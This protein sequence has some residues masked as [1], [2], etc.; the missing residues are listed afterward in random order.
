MGQN[1]SKDV[2]INGTVSPGYES[3]KEMFTDNFRK[4]RE[5]SA[6][7]CVYVGEEKV[8]DIW[9]STTI[10]SY[11]ADTLTNVFSSTKSLTAI[12][13]AVMQDR[14]LIKYGAKIA[15][16][17]PEFGQNGK[18]EVTV[19]DLMRH[20]A[21][22]ATWD[23]SLDVQDALT[24]NIK[25]NNVGKVIENQ[26]LNFP[27]TG[28]RQYHGITRGWIA[29]E[30]FRRVHPK[31]ETI[32]EFLQ[33]ELQEPLNADV[34]V[35]I[36]DA[37]VNNY[38]PVVDMKFS[39]VI[40]QSMIP[41]MF[42]R[43]VDVNIFELASFLNMIRKAIKKSD[44]MKPAF[45]DSNGLSMDNQLGPFFNQEIVRRGETSSANGNCSARGEI[46]D[47]LNLF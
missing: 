39:F 47:V 14:G 45:A 13:M 4:G 44:D 9:G 38:A 15:E 26:K 24:E 31:G 6:Q 12:A 17:W 40:G 5:E 25:K 23:T 3:V 36:N 19:A 29:N 20:E 35:G 33:K 2:E 27:A 32:G 42:G 16:Y 7:L 1:S 18:E 10:P 34:F 46:Q 30:I 11:T 21:G 43:G 37:Y 22:L 8:V 41:H 28:K